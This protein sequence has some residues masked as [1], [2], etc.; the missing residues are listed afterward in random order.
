[1]T[2]EESRPTVQEVNGGETLREIIR[3]KRPNGNLKVLQG[4]CSQRPYL[5]KY[6]DL[7]DKSAGFEAE[8]VVE[9]AK[10]GLISGYTHQSPILNID[11]SMAYLMAMVNAKG[12]ILETRTFKDE[13]KPHLGLGAGELMKDPDVY[14]VCRAVLVVDDA[15][16]GQFRHLNDS[17]LVPTQGDANGFQTQTILILPRS[18]DI[19]YIGSVIQ[20]NNYDKNLTP[21]SP[22][23]E[24]MRDRS[25]DFIPR[26]RHAGLVP[27]YPPRRG[28]DE[29]AKFRLVHNFGHGGSGWTPA[30]PFSWSRKYW[31]KN[32]EEFKNVAIRA[33]ERLYGKQ[34]STATMNGVGKHVWVWGG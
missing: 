8:D 3:T 28:V 17:Y 14:P 21:E 25:G 1:M 22:E 5:K 6:E 7:K 31:S 32:V 2:V 34:E 15:R 16:K 11:K 24:P 4:T 9:M 19:P 18:D 12:T 27:E 23:V 13:K 33:N 29:R 26:L 20:P 30:L 10:T